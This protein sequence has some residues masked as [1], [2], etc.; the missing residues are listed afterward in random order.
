MTDSVRHLFMDCMTAREIVVLW[1]LVEVQGLVDVEV[2]TLLLIVVVVEEFQVEVFL[3]VVVLLISEE[4]V[5]VVSALIVSFLDIQL[6]TVMIFIQSCGVYML[7]LILRRGLLPRYHDLIK[8]RKTGRRIGGGRE[9]GGL[10]LLDPEI[11]AATATVQ[12]K[13]SQSVSPSRTPSHS[14]PLQ[15]YTRGPR[16]VWNQ[17]SS[18]VDASPPSQAPASDSTTPPPVDS[19]IAHRTRSRY[20]LSHFVSYHN[21]SPQ[22]SVFVSSLASVSVP[23]SVQEALAHP[24]T[25]SSKNPEGSLGYLYQAGVMKQSVIGSTR[26]QDSK[27]LSEQPN[28][29]GCAVAA[30]GKAI[31]KQEGGECR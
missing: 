18:P 14:Q 7:L 23:N 10:Y 30:K 6:T 11:I 2:G 26:F 27:S 13:E 16:R 3:V 31:R 28:F 12:K 15:V 1:W 4:V 5:E 25:Q 17:D 20:P 29:S 9:A 24:G 22:M 8:D 19:P 21:L